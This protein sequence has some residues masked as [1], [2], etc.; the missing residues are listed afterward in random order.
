[1]YCANT[2]PPS[3]ILG[4]AHGSYGVGGI[5]APIIGTAI[6]SQGILWSRFYF[7]CVG[8]RLCCIAFAAWSFWSYREDSE[9]TLLEATTSRQTSAENAASKLKNLK[10]ALKNKVT[11][12]GALFIFA[13]QG[14]E[15]SISGW[16]ISY[17]INYRNGDPAKVGYVTAGFWVCRT[18]LCCNRHANSSIGWNHSWP[19]CT[20]SCCTQNRRE[21]IRRHSHN[22]N[23]RPSASGMVDAELDWK[24]GRCM[25]AGFVVG[26][27]LPLCADHLF[28]SHASS[29]SNNCNRLHR[30]CRKFRRCSRSIHNWCPRTSLW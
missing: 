9:E 2:H 14:A 17:L 4:L 20:H 27:C 8:L 12:F 23:S 3:V 1:V 18:S 16:F 7:I 30:R 29:C 11:I 26:P 6:V 21:E 13:Y 28:S 15:V 22:W 5:I 10:L 25:L 24:C 19:F